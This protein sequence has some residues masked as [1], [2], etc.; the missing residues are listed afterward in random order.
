MGIPVVMED[1]MVKTTWVSAQCS[2]W[3]FLAECVSEGQMLTPRSGD[4]LEEKVGQFGKEDL[5]VS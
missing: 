1:K 3:G 4:G 5:K 2:H